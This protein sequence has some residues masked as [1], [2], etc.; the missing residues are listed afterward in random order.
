M[1]GG[2]YFDQKMEPFL[3]NV[4]VIW[5]LLMHLLRLLILNKSTIYATVCDCISSTPAASTI[6]DPGLGCKFKPM[7]MVFHPP[8]PGV[9]GGIATAFMVLK[10]YSSL[11]LIG[12]SISRHDVL[13]W[14][15]A[16]A[17]HEN[18]AELIQDTSLWRPNRNLHCPSSLLD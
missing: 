12:A 15:I 11:L 8:K 6:D 17:A 7:M 18:S 3:E 13:T 4:G 5:W 1:G 2:T 9:M 14:H 10:D 16:L